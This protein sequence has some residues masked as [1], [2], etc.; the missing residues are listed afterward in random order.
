MHFTRNM[1]NSCH[2]F[3]PHMF[4]HNLRFVQFLVSNAKSF[5]KAAKRLVQVILVFLVKKYNDED[6]SALDD[7]M[8]HSGSP[9]D[10]GL[11]A[12]I[13]R[14]NRLYWFPK[15][16]SFHREN[17]KLSVTTMP[18]FILVHHRISP[19]QNETDINLPESFLQIEHFFK[20]WKT[21]QKKTNNSCL[22]ICA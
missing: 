20:I 16:K 6:R 12:R 13:T 1:E 5:H 4:N 14:T 18:R 10:S 11:L 8:R 21:G 9:G 17:V 19:H 3:I 22:F 15:T 2:F 7:M